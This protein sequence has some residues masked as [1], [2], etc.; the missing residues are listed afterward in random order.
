MILTLTL[1]VVKISYGQ[2]TSTS[3]FVEGNTTFYI[4]ENTVVEVING[5]TQV[6]TIVFSD[7]ETTETPSNPTEITVV[8][9]KK[10]LQAEIAVQVISNEKAT[11]SEKT[12]PATTI[13]LPFQNFPNGSFFKVNNKETVPPPPTV[14][15]KNET[16]KK[17]TDSSNLVQE[18]FQSFLPEI[19]I[20][21]ELIAT[22]PTTVFNLNETAFFQFSRPPPIRIV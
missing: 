18:Y 11:S 8:A 20:Q 5:F 14:T 17:S 16:A 12:K 6:N 1:L 9:I 13:S 7:N 2:N 4:S 3:I 19:I 21:N 22:I 15:F 10:S